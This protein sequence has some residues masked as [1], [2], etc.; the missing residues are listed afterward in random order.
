M[1][2]L[3]QNLFTVYL[4]SPLSYSL[5]L[6]VL[7]LITHRVLS[8]LFPVPNEEIL[9]GT[10]NS[11]NGALS[12]MVLPARCLKWSVM[13]F[14]GKWHTNVSSIFNPPT[15]SEW[16]PIL[17]F[18]N[19]KS[20]SNQG[21]DVLKQCSKLLNKIQVHDLSSKPAEATLELCELLPQTRFVVLVCGGDGSVN[22]VLTTIDKLNLTTQPHVSVLPLGT[23]NDLANMLGYGTSFEEDVTMESFLA[24]L[25]YSHPINIDRWRITINYQKN[26]YRMEKTSQYIIHDQLLLY[27]M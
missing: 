19:R 25:R 10:I 9:T 7:G 21:S 5:G 26:L 14:R 24:Q 1:Q 23:G 16:R 17:V 8:W 20:G 13:N 3:L 22:W 18:S 2:D 11:E 12:D 4:Q 27:W 15:S 6:V